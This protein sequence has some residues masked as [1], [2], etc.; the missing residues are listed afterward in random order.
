MDA[1]LAKV[2]LFSSIACFISDSRMSFLALTISTTALSCWL[3]STRPRPPLWGFLSILSI[4]QYTVNKSYCTNTVT[5]LMKLHAL[6]FTV[7]VIV[8]ILYTYRFSWRKVRMIELTVDLFR[9][10]S[11][12]LAASA[13]VR[14]QFTT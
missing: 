3:V 4:K 8:Y 9:F 12:N 1:T 5:C 10:G 14:P 11:T 6:Q 2:S 7:N 13:I